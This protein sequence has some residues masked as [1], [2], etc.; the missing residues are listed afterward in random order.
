MSETRQSHDAAKPAAS[1]TRRVLSGGAVLMGGYAA[2]QVLRLVSNLIVARLVA[3]EAFGL[4]AVTISII[5]FA[6]MMTD[7]GVGASVVRSENSDDPRFLQTAWTVQIIRNVLVWILAMAGAGGIAYLA[8]TG[9]VQETSIFAN[10]L[11]PPVIL[12]GVLQILI[13]GFGSMNK[14]LAERH[15]DMKRLVSLEIAVQLVGMVVTIALAA[16]GWGVWALVAGA[17]ANVT[18]STIASHFYFPG[19]PMRLIFDRTYF[20]EIFHFG[21]WLIVASFFGF[22][23]NRGDQFLFGWLMDADRFSLYA[24]AGMWMSA[25]VAVFETVISRVFFPAFSEVLRDRPENLEKAYKSARL[26]AD[27]GVTVTAFGAFFLAIPVFNAL[28]PENYDGV[29]YF[30][31]L[32]APIFLLVPYRL[33]SSIVLASGDSRGFTAVTITGGLIIALAV[34]PVFSAFGE[35]AAV[36]AFACAALAPV[37]ILWR[38]GGRHMKIDLWVECRML[39]ALVV[40]AAMLL[41]R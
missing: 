13:S 7:I 5:I 27:A 31:T 35:R 36:V 18:A 38:L 21:K 11:L 4:M 26:I 12:W 23:I 33:I 40:L 22:I 30:V 41:A 19:P 17:L 28:Y 32:M 8:A 25:A 24:V 14:P 34:A 15:L 37:P 2:G 3:P 20:S 6:N 29:G 9:G 1:L 16:I 39:V 10:P